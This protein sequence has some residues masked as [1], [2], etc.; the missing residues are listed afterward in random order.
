[1][2]HLFR[3]WGIRKPCC[4]HSDS[5]LVAMERYCHPHSFFLITRKLSPSSQPNVDG[6]QGLHE[7][8]LRPMLFSAGCPGVG[9]EDWLSTV[10]PSNRCFEAPSWGGELQGL[11]SG[12]G[13]CS[14]YKDQWVRGAPIEVTKLLS[15]KCQSEG[16]KPTD[17]HSQLSAQRREG[18]RDPVCRGQRIVAN[19]VRDET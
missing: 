10:H 18:G 12:S 9:R 14:L 6:I 3:I 19:D 8:S 7:P 11:R 17:F 15:Q 16:I 13:H 5:G 2:C 1:M 4:I